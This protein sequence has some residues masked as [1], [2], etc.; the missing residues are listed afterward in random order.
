MSDDGETR[1]RRSKHAS[2][3]RGPSPGLAARI[4]LLEADADKRAAY[5]AHVAYGR[6]SPSPS[7]HRSL[8]RTTD[9]LSLRSEFSGASSS[10]EIPTSISTSL[11]TGDASAMQLGKDLPPTPVDDDERRPQ[12]GASVRSDESYAQD[13]DTNALTT[14]TPDT[15]VETAGN[16]PQAQPHPAGPYMASGLQ[17]RSSV[18]SLSR[19]S[20]AAQ[21]S[22]L[23]SL[24]VPLSEELSER[25]S[26]LSTARGMCDALTGA[27][28]Q[29]GRWIDTATKVLKGLDAEDDVEWAAQGKESLQEVDV[30]V[31]RFSNLMN[32]YVEFIDELQRRPDCGDADQDML[33]EILEAMEPTLLGWSR[34]RELL[35]GVKLQVETALEWNELWTTVLQEIQVELEACQTLVFEMEEKRHINMMEDH[36]D[37]VDIDTL[38]TIMEDTPGPSF[39]VVS[40]QN[41]KSATETEAENRALMGL[42]A[43][44]QPL[45]A[46]LDF[47][48]MRIQSF[49][50]RAEGIFPSACDDLE[51]R[52]KT[53]ERKWGKLNADAEGLKRELGEDRW[54][55]IF[56]NAGKQATAMIDSVER[57]MN[58]LKEAIVVWEESGWRTDADIGKK[59]ENYEAKKMH[60]G[61]SALFSE[62]LM[63]ILNRHRY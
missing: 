39:P 56:R 3:V 52:R 59:L 22:R 57:S 18:F 2:V 14:T 21:L 55:V 19:I 54:V 27:G 12:S 42:F 26:Q 11:D 10:I 32:V 4:K 51:S 33:V 13:D 34:V 37:S 47:L 41:G 35:K 29:I 49:Q 1:G 63:L 5:N 40:L 53:L 62:W 30:A 23:T 9:S 50:F 58:K 36:A 31:D 44:M 6:L 16:A 48:P 61:L 28:Q 20:F 24:S 15:S 17:R 60:Y 8:S 7:P 45:R 38:E 46:S 43:R 25:I